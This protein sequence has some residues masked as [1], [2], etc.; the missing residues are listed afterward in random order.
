MVNIIIF[1]GLK[2]D[3]RCKKGYRVIK[4]VE[5]EFKDI[6][7]TVEDLLGRIEAEKQMRVQVPMFCGLTLEGN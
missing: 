7:I 3:K 4:S 5:S 6:E 1:L 2:E